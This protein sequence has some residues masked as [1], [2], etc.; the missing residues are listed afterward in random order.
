MAERGRILIGAMPVEIGFAALEKAAGRARLGR[1]R[2]LD[3]APAPLI[4][5]I[6]DWRKNAVKPR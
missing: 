3:E 2:R 6:I 1:N 4:P 5:L